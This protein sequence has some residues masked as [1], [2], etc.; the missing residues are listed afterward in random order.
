MKFKK[1]LILILMLQL[2]FAFGQN[3]KSQD[4]INK[5]LVTESLKNQFTILLEKSND[6]QQYKNIKHFNLNKFKKNFFDSIKA[7]ELKFKNAYVKIN[8]QKT[9]IKK[10][11]SVINDSKNNITNLETEKNSIDLFGMKLSKII[12]NTILWSIILGLLLSTLFLLYRF[13]NS[14]SSTK[15][16]KSSLMELEGEFETHR[17]SSLER[18]QVLRRKLQ[19]EINKRRN[20]K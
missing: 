6:F 7:D 19:D 15:E 20:V 17:K 16:A 5:A 3:P 9:E 18:E 2:V 13:K 4:V 8:E 11:N 12:Y 10:L 1:Y 14:N